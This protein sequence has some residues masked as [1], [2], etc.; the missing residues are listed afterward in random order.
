MP[1]QNLLDKANTADAIAK[2]CRAKA[3]E[4]FN[5]KTSIQSDLSQ[6]WN[7]HEG[8]IPNQLKEQ[9]NTWINNFDSISPNLIKL[10]EKCE[11]KAKDWRKDYSDQAEK[12]KKDEEEKKNRTKLP[13]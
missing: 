4:T 10:A 7:T 1:D 2:K 8:S 13:T 12:E 6:F 5:L 3:P 11:Q 9:L